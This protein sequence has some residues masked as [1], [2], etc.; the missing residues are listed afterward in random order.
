MESC[1]LKIRYCVL[2]LPLKFVIFFW[3]NLIYGN[4][5][6]YMILGLTVLLLIWMGNCTGYVRQSH[7]V[8]F[9]WS[10]PSNAGRSFLRPRSLSSSWFTL[11]VSERL[12]PHPWPLWPTSPHSR[13]KWIRSWKNTNTTF[14]SPTRVPLHFQVK[15]PIDLTPNA[16]LPNGLGYHHSLLENEEIKPHIEEL[17]HKR[18]IRPNS[19][20][21]GSPIVLVKMAYHSDTLLDVICR[22]STYNKEMYSIVQACRQ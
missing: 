17:L 13:S 14:S 6:L 10:L 12:Q 16:P 7:L 18:R 11:K 8:L 21:C 19:S 3:T 4:V 22:Y 1:H 20:P 15:H 2:F 9:P 5:M